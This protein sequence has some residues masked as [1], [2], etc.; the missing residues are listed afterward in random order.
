MSLI[1]SKWNKCNGTKVAD[2]NQCS[3]YVNHY[4]EVILESDTENFTFN[5]LQRFI[6]NSPLKNGIFQNK[7][8]LFILS[9][10]VCEAL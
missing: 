8:S 5:K 2:E 10:A 1:K 9:L 3:L 7:W 6:T 4:S